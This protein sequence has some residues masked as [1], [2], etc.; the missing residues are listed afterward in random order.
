MR[1]KDYEPWL[2]PKSYLTFVAAGLAF[3]YK[4]HLAL[5]SRRAGL[6]QRN[7]SSDTEAVHV[8][9]RLHIVQRI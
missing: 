5:V 8:V 4:R 7:V 6:D 1:A 3:F 2:V 9:A